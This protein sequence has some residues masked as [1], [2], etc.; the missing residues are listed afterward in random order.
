MLNPQYNIN[1]TAG[2]RLGSKQSEEARLKFSNRLKGRKV[3]AN[4]KKSMLAQR[5]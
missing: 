4:H 2:S 5:E 1:P 3:T